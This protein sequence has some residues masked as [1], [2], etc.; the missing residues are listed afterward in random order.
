MYKQMTKGVA[1]NLSA[2]EQQ[3]RRLI[4]HTLWLPPRAP[5]GDVDAAGQGTHFENRKCTQ[6]CKGPDSH[7]AFA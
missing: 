3:L 6:P 7:L 4:K 2:C 5:P 1:L